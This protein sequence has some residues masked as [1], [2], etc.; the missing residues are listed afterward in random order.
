MAPETPERLNTKNAPKDEGKSRR[1]AFIELFT[2]SK[3]GLAITNTGRG[4]RETSAQSQFRAECIKVYNSSNPDPQREFL[5][6]PILKTWVLEQYTTAAHLF[7]YMHGQEVM[8]TVFGV[9]DP[10][11]LFSPRNG[12]IMSNVVEKKFDKGFMAI[13]PRLPN[14]PTPAQVEHWN[15]KE[16]KE[17]KVRI[18][19][20]ENPEVHKVIRPD[21]DQTWKDLDG[22]DVEFRSAFRPRARYLYFNYCIQILRRAWKAERS[23]AEQMRQEFNAGFWGTTGSYLPRS[24]LR[25][26][27]E[28]LGHGYEELSAG[29][30]DDGN[31]A[32]PEDKDL[33]LA[34]ASRQVMVP[35]DKEGEDEDDDEEGEDEDDDEEGED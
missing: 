21:S 35:S 25:A 6:C 27:V 12:M 1:R 8:D 20:L 9:M 4:R 33:L 15:S 26:F 18:L 29:A 32:N 28:E 34:I 19:D 3:I 22:A 30:R 16:P 13:V 2:T 10:P 31:T 23:A 17:Y 5:W 11:E 14:R 7:A 24:M